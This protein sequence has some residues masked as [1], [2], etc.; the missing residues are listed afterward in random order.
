[1]PDRG[2]DLLQRPS[3]CRPQYVDR[4]DRIYG[5][6]GDRFVWRTGVAV[7]LHDTPAHLV[8]DVG[9]HH[10]RSQSGDPKHDLPLHW[11][12]MALPVMAA[13]SRR[14]RLRGSTT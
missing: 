11:V 13:T 14:S 12:A 9:E 2:R 5:W 6:T 3:V 4:P 7:G 10:V 1:M 8:H